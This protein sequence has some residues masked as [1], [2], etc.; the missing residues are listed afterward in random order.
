[1]GLFRRGPKEDAAVDTAADVPQDD[2]VDE[3][4]DAAT[5]PAGTRGPWDVDTS[6]PDVPRVDLGAI[7]LPQVDGMEIRLEVDKATNVVSAVA[8]LLDGSSLQLQAFAAPR[9][10][11]IKD[12]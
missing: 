9:T 12:G 7:R 2:T 1:M 10:A 5:G 11:G 4:D 6:H 8:V 3:V